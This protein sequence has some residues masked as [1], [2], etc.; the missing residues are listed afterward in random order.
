MILNLAQSKFSH[1]L[2]LFHVLTN[3]SLDLCMRELESGDSTG[4][5]EWKLALFAS[6]WHRAR[7]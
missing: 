7:L 1:K 6:V 2:P 3:P 5:K 4:M